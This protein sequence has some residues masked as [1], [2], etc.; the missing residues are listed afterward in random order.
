MAGRLN[1]KQIRA[2]KV[3]DSVRKAM[4]SGGKKRAKAEAPQKVLPDPMLE[5]AAAR[6]GSALDKA[7]NP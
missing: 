1:P 5:R 2:T 6:V 7:R 4:K 3:A